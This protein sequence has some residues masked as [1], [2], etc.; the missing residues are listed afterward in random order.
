MLRPIKSQRKII[1]HQLR[2]FNGCCT[3]KSKEA[4]PDVVEKY[5]SFFLLHYISRFQIYLAK[6]G[7][8]QLS[9]QRSVDCQLLGGFSVILK[10]P[11]EF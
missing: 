3:V 7:H 1:A 4:S 9:Q 8:G 2:A 5:Q 6:K 11:V 10:N